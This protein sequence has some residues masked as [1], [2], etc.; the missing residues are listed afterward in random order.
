MAGLTLAILALLLFSH[1]PAAPQPIRTASSG[2][3][4]P[5][6]VF[7]GVNINSHDSLSSAIVTNFSGVF[8]TAFSWSSTTGA[9]QTVT[10]VQIQLLFFGTSIATSSAQ[11]LQ[12][13]VSGN[14]TLKSD[15]TQNRYIYEGVYEIKATISND[16]TTLY[17]QNFFIWIQATDHLTVVNIVLIALIILEIYEVAALGRVKRPKKPKGT[18]PSETTPAAQPTAEEAGGAEPAADSEA[19]ASEGT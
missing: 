6:I 9:P 16:G 19:P 15:F 7:N 4:S 17:S 18:A 8:S 12:T 14:Y 5:T 11:F 1:A 3:L 10:Q 13:G 2:P